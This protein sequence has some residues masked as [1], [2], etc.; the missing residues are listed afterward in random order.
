MLNNLLKPPRMTRIAKNSLFESF[1]LRPFFWFS[2]LLFFS[3]KTSER[4]N[5]NQ[6]PHQIALL[7][8]SGC[9]GSCPTFE[10]TVFSNK[11]IQF[12][13]YAFVPVTG[14]DR[15][16]LTDE[17][18]QN[19]SDA[20]LNSSFLK[21]D[22]T[23]LEPIMDIPTTRIIARINGTTKRVSCNT[24]PPV[25]F[26]HVE[27]ALTAPAM[28]RGWLK[29]V[30]RSQAGE[31][32]EWIIELTDND[33]AEQLAEK[34]PHFELH[35]VK[36]IS[37][38]LSYFLYQMKKPDELSVDQVREILQSDPLVKAIELNRKLKTRSQ[39]RGDN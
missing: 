8:K 32:L 17:E 20:I 3:C 26:I 31:E 25:A 22:S 38:N 34:Y 4:L 5:H 35:L 39:G 9:L 30:A 10:I 11:I 27:E 2:I 16:T 6:E 12:K 28:N 24:D 15:D 19:I 29:S 33:S 7:E 18:F 21:L 1:K 37:P 36:R 23:Y 14:E 13:G